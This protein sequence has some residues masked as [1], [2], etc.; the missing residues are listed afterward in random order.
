MKELTICFNVSWTARHINTNFCTEL[1]AV[2]FCKVTKVN[3]Q[4]LNDDVKLTQLC[5]NSF[6]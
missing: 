2:A 3:V 1:L 5:N 6:D 4:L